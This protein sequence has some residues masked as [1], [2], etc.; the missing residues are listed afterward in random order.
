MLGANVRKNL[1]I[2]NPGCF[3]HVI[4]S[5]S[6]ENLWKTILY[7]LLV[8]FFINEEWELR[9]L[10]MLSIIP[11]KSLSK[12]GQDTFVLPWKLLWNKGAR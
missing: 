6:L 11:I 10:Q 3:H 12:M 9:E 7:V 5:Q 4:S 1:K 8:L 2:L